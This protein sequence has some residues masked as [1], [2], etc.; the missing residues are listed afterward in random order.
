[1]SNPRPIRD[2]RP[3]DSK[4]APRGPKSKAA[5]LARRDA[6]RTKAAHQGRKAR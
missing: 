5:T 4:R 2:D 1:M 3:R 6:R